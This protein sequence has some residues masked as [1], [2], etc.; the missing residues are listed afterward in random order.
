MLPCSPKCILGVLIVFLFVS[1][2]FLWFSVAFRGFSVHPNPD[3]TMGGG[4]KVCPHAQPHIYNGLSARRP[5]A[6]A[7]ARPYLLM[8]LILTL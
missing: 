5:Q 1:S 7:P 2:T 4:G 6:A 8:N 3:H